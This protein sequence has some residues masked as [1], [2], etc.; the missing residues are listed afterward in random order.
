[1]SENAKEIVNK[2]RK[3]GGYL[4]GIYFP[5]EEKPLSEKEIKKTLRTFR[6]KM[7]ESAI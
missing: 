1:M 2:I 4:G 6:K 3:N 5:P 7:K